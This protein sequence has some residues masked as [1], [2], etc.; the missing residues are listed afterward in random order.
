VYIRVSS[1][2]NRDIG[3]YGKQNLIDGQEETC[4]NSEQGLPQNILLDFPNPVSVKSVVFQFQGGFVGKKCV[5]VGSKA[6]SPN[7]YNVDLDIIYPE[8]INS[9]QTFDLP[10]TTEPLKR[11]KI[12]FEESTDFYGRITVYKLDVLG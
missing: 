2:L 8:D 3:N 1:V 4:W 11:V 9:T 5:I 10:T 6:S 7:E 12:I